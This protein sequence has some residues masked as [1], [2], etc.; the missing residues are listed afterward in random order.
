MEAEYGAL[1]TAMRYV[2][3]IKMLATEISSNVGLT[4]EPITHLRTI[5]WEDITG[6]LN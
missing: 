6:A 3:P 2:L 1:S 5:A 4:Q